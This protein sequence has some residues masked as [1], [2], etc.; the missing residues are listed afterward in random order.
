MSP[1]VVSDI[2]I[3][4]PAS[5]SKLMVPYEDI[6]EDFR[7]ERGEARKWV[8]LQQ[9][10]FFQGLPKETE[11]EPA[12]GIDAKVALRHLKAIMGSYEPKHEHKEA[13]VA[14]LMSQWFS[15]VKVPA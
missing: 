5:V 15:D 6:P 13:C 10:W 9:R 1:Q 4:F 2:D 8:Q 7:R 3:A 12:E 11:F 14:Y